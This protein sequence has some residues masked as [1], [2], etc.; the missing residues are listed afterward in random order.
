M[1]N[2]KAMEI[3]THVVA[4]RSYAAAAERLGISRANVTKY[5]MQLEQHLGARLLN[6]TTRRVSV[7]E[8]GK[9]YYGFCRR[10]LGDIQ[11]KESA[12]SGSQAEA[13]GAIRVMAPKSFGGLYMGKVVSDFHTRH[14]DIRVSLFMA[15]VSLSA[16]DLVENGFDLAIRL[17]VQADSSL[18]SR[19]IAATRWVLCAAPAYVEAQGRPRAL[20]DLKAHN[21][22]LHSKSPAMPA[23][24]I[25]K[26]R[27]PKRSESVKVSGPLT[28]NSVMVLRAAAL[29]GQGIALL[30]TYCIGEDL[31]KKDLVE[32]LPTYGGPEE[33]ISVLFPHR[34]YLPAKSRLFIDFMAEVF[35]HPPWQVGPRGRRAQPRAHEKTAPYPEG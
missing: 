19:R 24:A 12:I 2:L 20:K 30:P 25:W 22:L 27:G 21:C 13:K 7:T 6:R 15:D 17:T 28:A 10:V 3:Y 1:D 32:V 23:S 8:V 18:V 26:F 35:G 11:D 34:R 9:D 5:V 4:A 14:R 33:E 31:V 16:I 29:A